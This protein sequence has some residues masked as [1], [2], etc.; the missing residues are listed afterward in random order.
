M[1][2]ELLSLAE[3]VRIS[4][5]EGHSI[6]AEI[7]LPMR[8]VIHCEPKSSGGQSRFRGSLSDKENVA[9]GSDPADKR[10]ERMT[11]DEIGLVRR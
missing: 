8:V 5:C 4:G 9:F 11:C 7:I 6:R 10:A 3:I 1:S 2:V